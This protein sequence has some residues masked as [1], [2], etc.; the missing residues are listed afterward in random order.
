MTMHIVEENH[1]D[2]F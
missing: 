2:C 1:T